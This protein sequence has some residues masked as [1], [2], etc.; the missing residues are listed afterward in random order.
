MGS[1]GTGYLVLRELLLKLLIIGFKV[2]S[3]WKLPFELLVNN[4]GFIIED[5]L[6]NSFGY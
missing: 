6:S 4:T 2:V 5:C 1:N 3:S